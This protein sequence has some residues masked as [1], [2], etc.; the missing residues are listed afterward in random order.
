MLST[1]CNRGGDEDEDESDIEI[2]EDVIMA[3]VRG[4]IV[5]E[6]QGTKDSLWKKQHTDMLVD[7]EEAGWEKIN[8]MNLKQ[9]RMLALQRA[10][11]HRQVNKEIADSVKEMRNGKIGKIGEENNDVESEFSNWHYQWKNHLRKLRRE[12]GKTDVLV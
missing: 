1:Q 8:A 12:S 3:S 11:R 2:D 6:Q 10:K 9:E 5:E 4:E 7:L